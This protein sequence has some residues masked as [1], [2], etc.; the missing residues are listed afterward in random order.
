MNLDWNDLHYFIL[1]VEKQTLTATA[2]AL[3]VEH[4]TVS[5]RIERLEKQLAVHLFDRINKRYLLT[6]EGKRLYDEAK[7]LQLNIHQFTQTAKDSRQSIDEVAV[8]IP[9]F[10]AKG[11]IAPHLGAFYQRF[12]NIRL[13][14]QSESG[15]SNLHQRQADIALR[16]AKPQQD[17]LVAKRLR[18][19]HYY[20][21]AHPHYLEH[22][23]S[24][25]RQ[26]MSLNLSGTHGDWL[27]TELTGKTVRF[28]CNDFQLMKSAIQQQVGIGLLPDCYAEDT[29]FVQ[30]DSNSTFSAPMYLVMHEDVRHAQ[31]V[32]AVADFLIEVLG[33]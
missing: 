30:V 3:E 5:R 15:V 9:P 10:V 22:T 18:N 21:Y 32:R 17:D 7:K 25:K 12:N 24:E 1:L 14:L 4:S 28:V 19:V 13:V 8:S 11:L 29:D 16:I 23:P 20:W 33:E 2:N 27:Q 26:Y 6:D 31:K